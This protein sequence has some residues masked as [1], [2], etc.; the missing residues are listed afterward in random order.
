MS[1]DSAKLSRDGERLVFAGRLDRVAAPALWR[2]ASAQLAGAGVPTISRIVLNDVTG[3]DSAGLALLAEISAR[4][5]KAGTTPVFEGDPPGLSALRA[6]YRL[7]D[8]LA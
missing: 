7:T 6:A 4:L 1:D 2:Q 5:R 3:L 8:A